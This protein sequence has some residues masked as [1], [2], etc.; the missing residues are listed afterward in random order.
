[1]AQAHELKHYHHFRNPL[2][3]EKKDLLRKIYISVRDDVIFKFDFFETIAND[4]PKGAWSI[5]SGSNQ[6]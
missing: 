4:L 6:S 2:S 1:V 3:D 5:Q